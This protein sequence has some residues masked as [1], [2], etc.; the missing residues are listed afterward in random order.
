MHKIEFKKMWHLGCKVGHTATR[1]RMN[2]S[3][4]RIRS[5]WIHHHCILQPSDGLTATASVRYH[6]CYWLL[7]IVLPLCNFWVAYSSPASLKSWCSTHASPLVILHSRE[8][9]KLRFELDIKKA[10]LIYLMQPKNAL[11]RLLD[12]NKPICFSRRYLNL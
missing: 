10:R 5:T 2:A 11:E 3:T 1:W 9:C 4:W 8:R 12:Q 7:Y 6:S